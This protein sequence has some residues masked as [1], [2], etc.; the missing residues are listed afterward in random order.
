MIYKDKVKQKRV[1]IIKDT[2][3]P[4]IGIKITED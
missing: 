2:S 1:E 4:N 3:K